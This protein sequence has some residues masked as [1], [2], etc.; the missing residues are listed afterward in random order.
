M[1][2]LLQTLPNGS[3]TICSDSSERL[4]DVVRLGW[5]C[6]AQVSRCFVLACQDMLTEEVSAWYGHQ[7]I[8]ARLF[9]PFPTELVSSAKMILKALALVSST[10]H[11]GGRYATTNPLCFEVVGQ[12]LSK[13]LSL[14]HL[15]DASNVSNAFSYCNWGNLLGDH[16]RRWDQRTLFGAVKNMVFALQRST[17]CKKLGRAA[18]W[19]ARFCAFAQ[20]TNLYCVFVRIFSTLSGS[21]STSLGHHCIE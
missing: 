21:N 9:P 13:K 15:N 18:D 1:D 6:Q 16:K 19:S 4:E 7:H 8:L 20:T 10:T 3:F 14:Q 17:S 12:R 11:K 5:Q 2:E